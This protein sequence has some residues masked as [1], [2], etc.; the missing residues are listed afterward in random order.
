MIDILEKIDNRKAFLAQIIQ[1]KQQKIAKSR[2]GILN[3]GKVGDRT[4]FYYKESPSAKRRYVKKK[5]EAL[6]RELCQKDYDQK[7]VEFAQKEIEFL[8]NLKDCYPKE[9]VEGIY[10]M[11]HP[12]RKIYVQPIIIPDDEYIKAWLDTEYQKKGFREDYPEYYTN[13]GERVRSKTEILIANEL[14]R[15]KIPY[16][17]EAPLYLNEYGQIHP[18]FTVLNKQTRKE[19]YWE[20]LGMMDNVEYSEDA[21]K[22]ISAYEKNDIFPG[23][24]LILTHETLKQPISSKMISQM[25]FR[26][27]M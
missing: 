23:E 21:L 3:I 8:T 27:L 22:K 5:E 26:Y 12:S 6:V 19:L 1:E 20:H 24:R 18:D 13:N 25:I 15:Y 7:L 2:K 11:L 4:H 17:Y 14:N 16:K 10:E 9:C